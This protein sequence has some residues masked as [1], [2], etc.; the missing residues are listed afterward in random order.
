[1][2]EKSDVFQ[3]KCGIFVVFRGPFSRFCG[4]KRRSPPKKQ[5]QRIYILIVRDGKTS[6]TAPFS[7]LKGTP[8]VVKILEGLRVPIR[9]SF[10]RF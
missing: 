10:R 1:M 7:A 4:K 2:S 6:K 5:F 9:P 8:N 3:Q